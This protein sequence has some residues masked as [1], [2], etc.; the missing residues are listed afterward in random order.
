MHR[1]A[2]FEAYLKMLV[3]ALRR[4]V[5]TPLALCLCGVV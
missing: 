4:R 2:S 3:V 5:K 1:F